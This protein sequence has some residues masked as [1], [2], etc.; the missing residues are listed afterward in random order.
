MEPSEIEAYVDAVMAEFMPVL[1]DA[2]DTWARL[3]VTVPT[4][5]E[6]AELLIEETFGPSSDDGQ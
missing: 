3:G 4:P 5:Q 1:R 2:V 6:L